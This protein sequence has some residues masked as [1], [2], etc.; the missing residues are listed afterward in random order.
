MARASEPMMDRA[1]ESWGRAMISRLSRAWA[2]GLVL[3]AVADGSAMGQAA[4]PEPR[5]ETHSAPAPEEAW[6]GTLRGRV[7][8]RGDPPTQAVLIRRG[9]ARGRD[10]ALLLG[11]E[12]LLDETWVVDSLSRGVRN[13]LVY[14]PKPTA[15]RESAREAAARAVPTFVLAS[16]RF[17]PHVFAAMAASKVDVRSLDPVAYDLHVHSTETPINHVIPPS[18]SHVFTLGA[19]ERRPVPVLDDIH[20]W[21]RSWWYVADNPYFAVTDAQGRFEIKDVPAG[22][23]RVIVWHEAA[24]WVTAGKSEGKEVAIAAGGATEREF[25]IEAEHARPRRARASPTPPGR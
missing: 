10:G 21:M 25:T 13:V 12:P 16:G 17:D 2:V 14:L 22:P 5:G 18:E 3:G 11:G 7:V 8:F 24:G 4:G 23:Q 19:A 20:P 9:E 6:W 15:V 1:V